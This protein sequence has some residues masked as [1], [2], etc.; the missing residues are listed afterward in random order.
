MENASKALLMAGGVLL[1]ILVVSLLMYAISMYSDYQQNQIRLAEIEDTAKFNQQFTNYERDDVL[2]YEVL[3]LANKV[4]DYN[5]RESNALNENGKTVN[6]KLYPKISMNIK[7]YVN[8]GNSMKNDKGETINKAYI[9]QK[10]CAEM[11]VPKAMSDWQETSG[12]Y[13]IIGDDLV[14]IKPNFEQN[15]T[16]EK[17]KNSFITAANSITEIEQNPEFGS[18][19]SNAIALQNLVKEKDTIYGGKVIGISGSTENAR[20]ASGRG[21]YE[22]EYIKSRYKT[23]TGIQKNSISDIRKQSSMEDIAKYYEYMQFKKAI[24]KCT[25]VGY[26]DGPSGT[27]RVISINFEFTGDIK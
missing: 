1:T 4:M 19:T 21:W 17:I 6:D 25:G 24:F 3:S 10:F 22:E 9:K 8:S 2:G 14:W 7:M 13:N 18:N 20:T 12:S 23:L 15:A 16:Q 11:K 27:E 26:D 5:N